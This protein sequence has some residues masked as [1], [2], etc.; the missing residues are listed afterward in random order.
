MRQDVVDEARKWLGVPW[1][2]EGRNHAGL[3]CV[4]LGVVVA[5]A[6]GITTYDVSGYSRVPNPSLLQ[7]L[8]R[9]GDEIPIAQAEPGDFFA[10]RDEAYP[11]HVA[12]LSEKDGVPHIIHAHARRRMVVEESFANEWPGLVTHAFR[13]RK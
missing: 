11:F 13:F 5:R 8:K 7:H 6:L 2:H 1:R 10:I 9:V 4:G 12:F 3:D